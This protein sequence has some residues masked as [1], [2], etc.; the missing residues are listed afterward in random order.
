M[1]QA[2]W[3]AMANELTAAVVAR[4]VSQGFTPPAG[5]GNFVYGWKSLQASA[6][7]SGLVVNGSNFFP[8]AE[9]VRISAA[10]QRNGDQKS[11]VMLALALAAN[12]VTSDGYLI[13]FTD[14]EDPSHL[15]VIKGP[16]SDGIPESGDSVLMK[17]TATFVQGTWVHLQMDVIVQPHGDVHIQ[18][19]QNDLSANDV[20][21]PS[22]AAIDGMPE[23]IDDVLGVRSGTPPYSNGGYAGIAYY[24]E[25]IGRYGLIDHVKVARQI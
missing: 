3:T 18:V 11:S 24:T 4:G 22:W 9:G 7:V 14:D 20:T 1:A 13:G 5:G 16:P 2:D 23:Y 21:S 25:E 15:V 10:L 19:A 6:G 8:M 17:S 12:D